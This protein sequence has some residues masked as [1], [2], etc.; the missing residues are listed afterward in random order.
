MTKNEFI[1]LIVVGVLGTALGGAFSYEYQQARVKFGK[2]HKLTI[3]VLSASTSAGT[4]DVGYVVNIINEG[5]FVE[6]VVAIE[7][8]LGQH[9]K[10]YMGP[11]LFTQP[12]DFSPMSVKP[13]DQTSFRLKTKY[14]FSNKN[15]YLF[16]DATTGTFSGILLFKIAGSNGMVISVPL[17][18]SE[19]SPTGIEFHS[20]GVNVD[21]NSAKPQLIFGPIK[22][23]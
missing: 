14:D 3:Q 23:K 10:S 9:F 12:S 7:S 2:I 8:F 21:F 5:D 15:L 16:K 20:I 4:N 13:G 17:Y 18:V 19:P 22:G 6:N 1:R 11:A